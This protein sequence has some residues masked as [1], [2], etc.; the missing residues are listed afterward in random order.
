MGIALHHVSLEVPQAEVERTV[1][2]WELLGFARLPAPDEIA[3]YVTWLERPPNQIHLIH[4]DSAAV[5]SL[6][7]PAVVAPEFDA[8]VAA[9]REAGFT[10]EDAQELWGEPRAFAIAPAGHRVEVMAAPP[11]ASAPAA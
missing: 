8:T 3:Q 1:E 5:P 4:T 11:P 10:V 2:F 7:H 9:L 6:G